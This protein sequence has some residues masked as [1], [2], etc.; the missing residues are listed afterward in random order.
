MAFV[1]NKLKGRIKEIF[2]TQSAFAEAVGLSS[3]SVSA[4]L[5]NG[6]EFKPSEIMKAVDV[7][8]IE[9]EDIPV[10]FF[11]QDVQKTEQ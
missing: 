10:Y 7:L 3:V 6:V 5:N 2:G 9:P 11:T 1:Y 8:K 4:K